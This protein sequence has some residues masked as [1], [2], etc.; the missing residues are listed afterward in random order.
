MDT[1]L[2]PARE[3]ES[4]VEKVFGRLKTVGFSRKTRHRGVD[5]VDWM[6]GFGV[7]V[8]NLIRM[9]NPAGAPA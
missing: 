4:G 6:C 1:W 7:A 3:R 9:R 8:Y 5:R 2:Q